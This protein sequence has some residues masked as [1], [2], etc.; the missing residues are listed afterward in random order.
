MSE[1]N[2][3]WLLKSR[4]Q[5]MIGP[6]HF[7]LAHAPMPE[8]DL[9]AGQVLVKTLMLSFDP[10]MRG[11]VEDEPS[12]LPPVPVG[13]PMR[14]S[15]IGQVVASSNPD[16]PT[17]TLVQGMMNWQEY[18]VG[19]P[20]S[21]LMPPRPLPAGTPPAMAL[22]V[23]G[24]TSLTAYFGL[25]HVGQP[26]AG[27]T[28][29]VSGAAGATGSVV[30]QIA[31]IKGCRVIGI[32]GGEDKCQWLREQCRIEEVIDYRNQDV[33]AELARRCP[34]GINVFFDNVGG[35]TLEAGI[36][37]MADFGRIVLCGAISGYNDDAPS[38]GPS[39]I[40]K[41]VTRRIR[42]QGF[43]VIDFLDQAEAAY[44]DLG[45]WVGAGEIAWREDIQEGF[46]NIPATLLRLFDGRN[47]GKQLLKLADPA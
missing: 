22:G 16:L 29:L 6:E 38:P 30:A 26:Q 17:G 31:R 32:A 28:V 47:Q 14:A 21:A 3:Q 19:D 42:M 36:E 13:E 37:Q 12:Y 4:P 7:E 20:A 15:G 35:A 25:L 41:L 43:I 18:S 39:N 5:G 45:Q 44:A 40:M 11:W 8:P 27:E 9:A 33:A 34:M 2:R 24:A 10:A 46:E 1:T 23:F